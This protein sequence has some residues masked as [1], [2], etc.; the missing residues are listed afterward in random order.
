M[1]PAAPSQILFLLKV[2]LHTAFSNYSNAAFRPTNIRSAVIS[3]VST[4][5]FFLAAIEYHTKDA[6]TKRRPLPAEKAE[7][8]TCAEFENR[9]R[10]SGGNDTDHLSSPAAAGR[11]ELAGVKESV[12]VVSPEA[13]QRV[14]LIYW[15]RHRIAVTYSR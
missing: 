11:A 12:I 7:D 13:N 14:A 1:Y 8:A 4:V 5:V 2:H 9:F 6:L 10:H 3:T 15:T